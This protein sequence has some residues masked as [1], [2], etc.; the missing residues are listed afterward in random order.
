[1][2]K[3]LHLPSQTES[4]RF[5]ESLGSGVMG[6]IEGLGNLIESGIKHLWESVKGLFIKNRNN[7]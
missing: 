3:D 7:Q 5:S 4:Q 2:D 6:G 1:M